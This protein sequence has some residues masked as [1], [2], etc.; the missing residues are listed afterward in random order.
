MMV[1]NTNPAFSAIAQLFAANLAEI[2]ID[3]AIESAALDRFA[4]MFYGDRPAEERPHLF[5]WFWAPD[6][7]DAWSHLW[8]QLS[9][10][11]WNEGNAGHYCNPRVEELLAQARD[12]A[13]PATYQ[14]ALSEIQQIAMRDDP[15]AIYFAQL[16]WTTV[17]RRDV[18][19]YR[20]HPLL[21]DLLD[22]YHLSR[23]A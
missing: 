1:P 17:I 21:P 22:F 2:G 15:A 20:Q 18:A 9:G 6:Y 3:L 23:G 14:V 4:A 13:D 5:P 10:D 8:P 12:A 19:G 7:D 16:P 11:A